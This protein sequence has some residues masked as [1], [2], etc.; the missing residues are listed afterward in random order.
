MQDSPLKTRK[1]KDRSVQVFDPLRHKYVALT[2]EEWVRQQF[3]HFLI[4]ER[5]F[6]S[7]LLGNEVS[8][9]VGGANRRCDTILFHKEGGTPRVI[10]EYKAPEIEI[11]QKVFTQIS[12]YNSVLHADYLIVSN[13]RQNICCKMDYETHSYEFLPDIPMYEDL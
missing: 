1:S 2:P 3:T 4:N 9:C 6:P 11:T 5:H 10:I 13:F 7:A 12:S 8:I